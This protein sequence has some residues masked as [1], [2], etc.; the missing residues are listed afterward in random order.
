MRDELKKRV[1]KMTAE[2]EGGWDAVAGDFDGQLLSWGPLQWNLG[3]G[4]LY[5]ILVDVYQRAAKTSTGKMAVHKLMGADFVQALLDGPQAF[6]IFVKSK[7]LDAKGQ[8]KAAYK[9]RLQSL[10][11][12]K[13]AQDAFVVGAE[14]YFKRAESLARTLGFKSERGFALCFDTVV[15]NGG[16]RDDHIQAFNEMYDPEKHPEEWMMLKIFAQV[17]AMKAN[18][19]WRS[20]VLSRKMT[21]AVG[22]G[23]VHGRFYDLEQDFGIFY[24]VPW[25]ITSM[26]C[27]IERVFIDGT[28]IKVDKVTLVKNKL[29]I[30]TQR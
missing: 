7:V 28:E 12:T 5:P 2:F 23:V 18:P 3:Q 4:T 19:K 14:G 10:A 20:D 8:V 24:H 9:K 29:Y 22:K 16:P 26:P 1:L 27:G 17:V 13:Y 30:R 15:Q 25:D 21:I 11:Y 6:N